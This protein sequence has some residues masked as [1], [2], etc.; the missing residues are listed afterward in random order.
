RAPRARNASATASAGS[1]WPAVPPAAIRH[2]GASC[3]GIARDVKEDADRDERHDEARAAV[4]DERQRDSGQRRKSHHGSQVDGRLAADEY[5]Q[6]R[7]EPLPE[8]ILAAERDPQAEVGEG[9]VGPDH[10]GRADEPELLADDREDHV[11]VRLGQEVRLLDAL[12]EAAPEDPARA[13]PDDRLHRL[14]AGAL[15]VVPRVDEAEQASAAV[16]LEPD[17][18][19]ADEPGDAEARAERSG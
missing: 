13:E 15:G 11:R 16:R 9:R 17:G 4:G 2:A 1:T 12:A 6:A 7:R 10:G 19:E 18:E 5:R 8:R 3:S 14:V